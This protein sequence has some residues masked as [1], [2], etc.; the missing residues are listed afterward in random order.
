MAQLDV[1]A[2]FEGMISGL[3]LSGMSDSAIAR[4][5]DV[6]K[7]TICRYA[8]GHGKQGSAELF[9]KLS[10]LCQERLGTLPVVRMTR[11]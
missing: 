4:G 3:R 5:A 2:L 11:R 9:I 7:A 6:S 8:A 10:G 1:S